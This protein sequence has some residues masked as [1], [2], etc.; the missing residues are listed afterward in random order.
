MK[1]IEIF[2]FCLGIELEINEFVGDNLKRKKKLKISKM[3]LCF[4]TLKI[5][6]TK[7]GPYSLEN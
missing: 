2:T 4:E 7:I 1:N 3:N 6:A 5:A